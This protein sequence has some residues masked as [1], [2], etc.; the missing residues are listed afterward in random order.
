MKIYYATSISGLQSE[1]SDRINRELIG[2]LKKFG[3]VLTEHFSN[4]DIKSI[5]EKNIE[6]EEIHDR[7]MKWLLESDVIIAEV[8][9]PSLGVGYE[10]GRAVEHNKKILCLCSKKIKRLSA[11]ITGNGKMKVNYYSSPDEAKEMIRNYF[12]EDKLGK[13]T[14][15]RM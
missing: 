9:N 6:N 8:S 5:G 14:K 1:D 4:P 15:R 10:L 13:I 2:Y 12:L 3:E 11:M 7:D